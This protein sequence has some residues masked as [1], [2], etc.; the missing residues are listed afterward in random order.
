MMSCVCL[1]WIRARNGVIWPLLWMWVHPAVLPALWRNS[2]SSVCMPLSAK[3]SAVKTLPLKFLQTTKRIKPLKSSLPL[4][5]GDWNL[6][7]WYCISLTHMKYVTCCFAVP[8]KSSLSASLLFQTEA[9]LCST[10]G[11]GSLQGPQTP[12][13]T[14]S[15]M[16]EGG[17]L[18][19]P[20]PAST[21]HTQMPPMPP[22]SRWL[23]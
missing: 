8:I 2:T 19:P 6:F 21:P 18:K 1:R 16:A 13:S 4:Q 11:S 15:S 23:S 10:A 3:L 14:S 5:V 12:Q 17:D 9:S 20:T 22:G 7:K